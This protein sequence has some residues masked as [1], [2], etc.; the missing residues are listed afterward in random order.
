[1]W[2]IVPA[3]G[4]GA[5]IQPLAF[6]KELLPPYSQRAGEPDR[7]RAV[8][9]FVVERMVIGG[10]TKICFIVSPGKSDILEYYGGSVCGQPVCY[11]VQ[12]EPVGLCDA[13]FRALP[14]IGEEESVLIGLPD[15]I[16]FPEDGFRELRGPELSFLL[17]ESDEPRRFDS[18]IMDAKGRVLDIRVKEENAASKWVWGALRLSGRVL[19]RLSDL[20]EERQR[21]DEFL[22]TLFNAYIARGGVVNGVCAGVT[23]LDLGTVPGYLKALRF[24][25]EQFPQKAAQGSAGGAG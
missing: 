21:S 8:S 6:S 12:P 13:I 10:A 25:G 3:A 23:Y 14:M 9:D 5:R 18:V 11:A 20:W 15:T 1:M 24:L 19:H 7:P 22:G 16:W 17:F 4:K 2:G